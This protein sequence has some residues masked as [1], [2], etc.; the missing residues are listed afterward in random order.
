[1]RRVVVGIILVVLLGITAYRIVGGKRGARGIRGGD[2]EKPVVELAGVESGTVRRVLSATGNVEAKSEV[3]VFS[4][5]SGRIEALAVDVGDPIGKQ[6]IIAQIERQEIALR[7]KQA[8]A[9]L[10]AARVSLDNLEAEKERTERLFAKGSVSQQKRDGIEAQYKTAQ[11]QVRQ[12][13]AALALAREELANATVRAPIPG[14]V[15]ERLVDVGTM[16]GPSLALITMVQMDTVKAVVDVTEKDVGQIRLG[17]PAEVEVDAYLDTAFEGHVVSI[18]PV[19]DRGSRTAKVEIEIPN[20]DHRL[21]PGMFADVTLV[22]EIRK[23]VPL[24]PQAALVTEVRQGKSTAAVFVVEGGKAVERE[25]RVGLANDDR[26]EVLGGLETGE[27][28]VV[29]GQHYL[30]GG[31]EVEIAQKSP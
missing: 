27:Q 23:N 30:K 31:E 21:K 16:V 26:I 10:Y 11:A 2:A 25:I 7:A 18:S 14:L 5:V 3:K 4:K 8:E 20:R 15:A 9:G 6:S 1:M 24:I 28:V 12:A 13:E 17:I 19:V 22:L 29:A